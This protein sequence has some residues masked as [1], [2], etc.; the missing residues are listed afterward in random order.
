MENRFTHILLVGLTLLSS[1]SLFAQGDEATSGLHKGVVYVVEAYKPTI[2]DAKKI[3]D[4]PSITDSVYIKPD[5][6]YSLLNQKKPINLKVMP[7]N[8]ARIKGEPIAQIYNG[9]A[10]IAG[11]NYSTF[12][13]QANYTTVRDKNYSFGTNLDHLSS[14]D[15]E[16]RQFN[17][18]RIDVFGKKFINKQHT[19]DL[20]LNYGLDGYQYYRSPSLDIENTVDLNQRYDEIGANAGFKTFHQDSTGLHFGINF[21]YLNYKSRLSDD[22]RSTS[23]NIFD[24]TGFVV[25]PISNS[26]IARAVITSKTYG[27][28]SFVDSSV[29]TLFDIKAT[30]VTDKDRLRFEYGFD[31]FIAQ[32]ADESANMKFYPIIKFSYDVFDNIVIPYFNLGGNV[33]RQGFRGSV[34]ENRFSSPNL[35]LQN[36]ASMHGELGVK[37]TVSSN[38]SYDLQASFAK[39]DGMAMFVNDTT[40]RSFD[41]FNLVYDSITRTSVKLELGYEITDKLRLS[42]KTIYNSYTMKNISTAWHKPTWDVSLLAEYKLKEK[43]KVT[44]ELYMLNGLMGRTYELDQEESVDLGTF[45][46]VNLGVEYNYSNRLSAFIHLNNLAS[47]SYQR[48]YNY[49]RYKFNVYGGF[50]YAF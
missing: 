26:T 41:C 14:R 28:S 11:G 19:L 15:S 1:I 38:L 13:G 33:T 22:I 32:V 30:A 46:D 45:L 49:P 42:Q 44:S 29:N 23:E 24:I 4:Y 35:R 9:Y 10:K 7:I 21:D 48:W 43:L 18:S 25:S 37:G 31:I 3:N 36:T 8:A 6:E 39:I 16:T 27:L 5:M 34:L 20:G 2:T 12:L 50:S 47:K 17:N 40:S